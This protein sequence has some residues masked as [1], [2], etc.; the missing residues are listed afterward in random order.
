MP[1]QLLHCRIHG[2]FGRIRGRGV[3]KKQKPVPWGCLSYESSL[4]SFLNLCFCW[5]SRLSFFS[6]NIRNRIL[7]RLGLAE[8]NLQSRI[9]IIAFLDRCIVAGKLKLMLPLQ[10]KHYPIPS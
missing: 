6:K 10:L 4:C 1:A 8:L 3:D 9:A 7:P 5:Q 2:V